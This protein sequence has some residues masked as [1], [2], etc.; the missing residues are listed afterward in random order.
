V[1][2]AI[3]TRKEKERI[4]RRSTI[5]DAAVS[6]FAEKGFQATT[7]D[8]IALAAEFGKGTIYNYFSS[9]EEIYAAIIEDV[10][11]NMVEI[12]Q[13]AD[14]SSEKLTEFLETYTKSLFSYCLN[15]RD[16]LIIFVREIAHFTTDIYLSDREEIINRHKQ[17]TVLLKKRFTRALKLKEIKKYDPDRMAI[18]YEHLIFPQILFLIQNAKNKINIEKEI[19]FILSIFFNGI[20]DQTKKVKS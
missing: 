5:M 4:F 14:S 20:L 7:L 2:E 18:L 6:F 3:L 15:N 12:I 8:E 11:K 17:V 13:N 19:D 9:K 1:S 10:S 16:A